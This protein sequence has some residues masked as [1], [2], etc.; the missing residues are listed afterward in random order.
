M[1]PVCAVLN[2]RCE[3]ALPS[4]AVASCTFLHF[5]G[6]SLAA[7]LDKDTQR[8]SCH[9]SPLLAGA[10]QHLC[11]QQHKGMAASA[12]A[13][14]DSGGEG[15]STC[16]HPF[17][18][19]GRACPASDLVLQAGTLCCCCDGFPSDFPL[20]PLRPKLGAGLIKGVYIYRGK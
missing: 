18:K 13:R 5:P 2:P 12:G 15:G 7:S 16:P 20:L 9:H 3:S 4:Q 6:F 1:S 19:S 8:L 10:A 17:G 14:Q 11:G